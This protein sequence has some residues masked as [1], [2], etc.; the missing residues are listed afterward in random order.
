MLFVIITDGLENASTDYR[1]DQIFHMISRQRDVCNWSFLFLAANQDAIAE[2]AKVG[3]GAQQAM[4][5]DASAGGVQVAS[6]AMSR[7]VSSFR[8]TGCAE[9][10]DPSA[11]K[12]RKKRKAVH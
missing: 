6:V 3:I 12:P 11:S 10:T 2:G 7:A 9:L 5:F 8:A 1:R 4:N